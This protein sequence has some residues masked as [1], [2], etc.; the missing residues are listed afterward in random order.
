MEFNPACNGDE[1]QFRNSVTIQKDATKCSCNL[2]RTK[3]YPCPHQL[4]L[5]KMGIA[6]EPEEW[7]S[8]VYQVVTTENKQISD[9]K[10]ENNMSFRNISLGD[11]IDDLRME[12]YNVN[13][14]TDL[15]AVENSILTATNLL[16][17]QQESVSTNNGL[18]SVRKSTCRKRNFKCFKQ[19]VKR[20]RND[21][22]TWLSKWNTTEKVK[23]QHPEA[24]RS[25]GANSRAASLDF[26][27]KFLGTPSGYA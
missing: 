15:K 13:D 4:Y 21:P 14:E 27:S 18:P 23:S 12:S 26:F 24:I 5:V 11:L 2:Y 16:G 3:S 10:T 1:Y 7:K 25:M 9:T 22:N 17:A 20:P 19:H 6:K 8:A